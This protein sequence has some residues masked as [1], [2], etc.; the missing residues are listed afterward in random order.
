MEP[1]WVTQWL[2]PSKKLNS[3]HAYLQYDL[4]GTIKD[5]QALM[6]HLLEKIPPVWEAW[7]ERPLAEF[8][9]KEVT[10]GHYHIF[11]SK[12]FNG[13]LKG[14]EGN[15]PADVHAIEAILKLIKTPP[16]VFPGPSIDCIWSKFI[17]NWK[18]TRQNSKLKNYWSRI[19]DIES[20]SDLLGKSLWGDLLRHKTQYK[21]LKRITRSYQS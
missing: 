3:I 9:D 10:E 19:K 11:V 5:N 6:N 18:F 7:N 21:V 14:M 2:R 8:F 13:Q 1:N 12:M 20:K 17:N 15:T 16:T 4:D